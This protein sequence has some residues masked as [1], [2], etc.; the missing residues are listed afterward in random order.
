MQCIVFL[1]PEDGLLVRCV[2]AAVRSHTQYADNVQTS[3][4]PSSRRL[5]PELAGVR[6]ITLIAPSP[7]LERDPITAVG[8]EA[9]ESPAASNVS[10][11][12]I[13]PNIWHSNRST[14]CG[15]K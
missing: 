1:K 2:S 13:N 9:C 4:D 3:H 12:K 7:N 14:A 10:S 6:R 11:H 8:V 5:R 15:V